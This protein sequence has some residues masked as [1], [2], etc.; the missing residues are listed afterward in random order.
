[1]KY[2]SIMKKVLFV[3][4]IFS[5]GLISN[6]Q[7]QKKIRSFNLSLIKGNYDIYGFYKEYQFI[8]LQLQGDSFVVRYLNTVDTIFWQTKLKRDSAETFIKKLT[9]FN[10][11][12]N[13][14]SKTTFNTIKNNTLS[15]AI[16]KN[17]QKFTF[18][19]PFN[20]SI[21]FKTCIAWLQKYAKEHSTLKA[22]KAFL[23]YLVTEFDT[24]Q[25]GEQLASIIPF[26]DYKDEKQLLIYLNKTDDWN[27]KHGILKALC[28]FVNMNVKQA[29]AKLFEA[30]INIPIKSEYIVDALICQNNDDFTKNLL[31]KA[32]KSKDQNARE[33]TAKYLAIQSIKDAKP[34]ILAYIHR[35]FSTNESIKPSAYFDITA[36][37]YDREMLIDLITLYQKNKTPNASNSNVLKELMHAIECNIECYRNIHNEYFFPEI[38]FDIDIAKKRLDEKI[39]NYL[40]Q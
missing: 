11:E 19:T 22:K 8:Q 10:L 35:S 12:K 25:S 34:E 29:I 2:S 16:D 28:K 4:F 38:T 40:K 14:S 17:V 13:Y 3:L 26:I 36:R 15:I 18:S 33:K 1:M 30:N 23:D 9:S 5:L 27:I 31:I 21:P 39:A 7:E 24:T 32:L 20:D 6:A 37:I